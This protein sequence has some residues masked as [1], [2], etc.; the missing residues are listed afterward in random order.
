MKRPSPFRV[1][2]KVLAIVVC[3][4]AAPSP[5]RL[6]L[7]RL[8]TSIIPCFSVRSVMA[9]TTPAYSAKL[10][11][12]KYRKWNVYK[13]SNGLVS[14]FVAPELGGRAIQLQLGDQEYFL[15][16]KALEGKVL[17]SRRTT[18]KPA[19]RTMVEIRFGPVRRVG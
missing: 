10:E 4:A 5:R 19:G 11:Q 15:V 13:L 2:L 8:A 3:V 14:L 6:G 16:N 17:P 12:T 18:S 1:V 9:A 7:N